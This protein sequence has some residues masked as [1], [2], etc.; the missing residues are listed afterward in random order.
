MEGKSFA[1]L[2]KDCNL[3]DKALTAADV[4]LIFAKA[5]TNKTERKI[6]FAEFIHAVN[7]MAEKKKVPKEE[8]AYFIST[9]NHGP[10]MKA[11]KVDQ[12]R[13]HDDKTTYTGVYANGGPT[14]V[15]P[16]PSL[17]NCFAV[18]IN[19]E[20]TKREPSPQKA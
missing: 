9:S 15:D 7:F 12:V 1:K 6:G 4:D 8:L 14:N 2:A 11:T 5:K 19:L 18:Q 17:A 3:L 10:I 16:M 13:L 20:E